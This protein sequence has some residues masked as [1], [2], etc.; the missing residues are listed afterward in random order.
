VGKISLPSNFKHLP[1]GFL[2]FLLLAIIFESF[3][4][5][6]PDSILFDPPY[7]QSCIKMKADATEGKHRFDIIVLGD[8]AGLSSIRATIL[9]NIL[10][11]KAYNLSV[12]AVQTYLMSYILLKRYLQ[13][14]TQ[15]PQMVVLQ[16]S[17]NTL[18]NLDLNMEFPQLKKS[19]LP[20]FRMDQDLL[21]ELK[22]P[23]KAAFFRY[24]LISV[25]PS[26]RRQFFLQRY[27]WFTE[28][29]TTNRKLY[30]KCLQM[31]AFEKGFFNADLR[32]Q[33]RTTAKMTKI[34]RHKKEFNVS[35]H[36]L[37]YIKRILQTLDAQDINTIVLLSPVREDE[38]AL[39]KKYNLRERLNSAVLSLIEPYTNIKAFWDMTEI[40]T[41]R[42]LFSDEFHLNNAGASIHTRTLAG[43]IRTLGWGWKPSK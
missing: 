12:I 4:L 9:E 34:S 14:G 6:L 17:A 27:G 13:S 41:E 23:V 36:N 8:C 16:L 20:Y 2:I 28:I 15:K 5:F 21:A 10:E 33:E 39:W 26:V 22:E 43:K 29:G 31:H 30:L 38:L 11:L 32:D 19:V 18:L 1:Q 42:I 37:K 3:I 24:R 40:P 35:P 25:L 7:E